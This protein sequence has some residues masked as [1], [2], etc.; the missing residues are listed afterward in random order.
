VAA[1]AP[2]HI[3]DGIAAAPQAAANPF[4]LSIL[5]SATR[6]WHLFR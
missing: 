4:K 6:A 3:Y 5:V 2:N 1:S